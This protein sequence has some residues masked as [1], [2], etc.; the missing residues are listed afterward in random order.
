MS[1]DDNAREHD[2]MW[3]I[4]RRL[5]RYAAPY[6]AAFGVAVLAMLL[7]AL[8][9][10][11]T[12]WLMKP[13]LDE[14]FVARDPDIIALIPAAVVAISVLR[15]F[16][17]FGATYFVSWISRNVIKTLRQQVFEK[18]LVMPAGYYDR[19]S[20][21]NLVSKI[22][23]NIEQV[24]ESSSRALLVLFGDALRIMV[25]IGYM[26]WMSWQLTIFIFVL[27]PL[28][29]FIVRWVSKRFR[30]YST[31]IQ[32]SMGDVTHVSEEIIL[33][34]RVIK[35]FG[36]EKY[37]RERFGE[38]NERNRQLF[39]KLFITKAGSVPV[40]QVIS[41]FGIAMIIYFAA[42]GSGGF[43]FTAGDFASYLGAMLFLAQPM[44][45]ITEINEPLQ[46]G[47]A[48]AHSIFELLDEPAQPDSGTRDLERVD[49]KVDFENISFAYEENKGEVLREISFSVEPGETIALI[50]RSGSGKSSLVNLIPRFYEPKSGRILVD[51]NDIRDIRLESLRRHIALVSQDV[52]L[53]NDTIARNIAYGVM[54]TASM[55]EI[56]DAARAAHALDFIEALPDGFD[57]QVGDRGLLLSGGQRQRIAIA[58]ALL[59]DAPILILDEATSALDTEAERHIQAALEELMQSRTTFVI[60]HRLSTIEKAD[61]ILVMEKGRIVEAGSHAE[62]LERDGIYARLHGMQF[63][64]M[65]D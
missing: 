26:L 1:K 60:A 59:K 23:Y 19:S 54:E 25:L 20:G 40:V 7:S 65:V 14:G 29:T 48:A 11:A 36:G 34:Q 64:D 21:G 9:E 50:G 10:G 57:T 33:G 16:G 53:F 17:S 58:R 37:E 63:A 38:V 61:R 31:R 3:P 13:L 6:K 4:Y 28:L 52:I 30:R 44:K 32:N 41:S 12:A 18:L 49:G 47:I 43:E 45:R 39:M 15:G 2:R 46:R 62:L 8:G 5:L 24:A 55:D 51:G 22:T 42:K 35:I 56:R 27:T